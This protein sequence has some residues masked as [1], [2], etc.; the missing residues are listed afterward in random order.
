MEERERSKFMAELLLV[1]NETLEQMRIVDELQGY[2]KK[3]DEAGDEAIELEE[4]L[5]AGCKT[6]FVR[7]V[8][9]VGKTSL[10]EYITLA[11]AKGLIYQKFKYVFLIKCR[12][13]ELCDN[14][15]LNDIFE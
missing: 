14:R 3:L 15:K 6:S 9:G 10:A 7:G 4:I 2:M 1:E 5:T 13:I 8:P 11:W 12:D